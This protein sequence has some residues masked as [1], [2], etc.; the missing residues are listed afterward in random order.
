MRRHGEEIRARQIGQHERK[1]R[2]V[3]H[4]N[5]PLKRQIARKRIF[6]K[7]PSD[8]GQDAMPLTDGTRHGNCRACGL[9]AELPD[10][11]SAQRRKRRCAVARKGE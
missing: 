9:A 8:V 3:V 6:R 7:D 11:F 10:R 4:Q 1:G 5:H 2:K